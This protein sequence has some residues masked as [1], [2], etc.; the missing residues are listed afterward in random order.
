MLWLDGARHLAERWEQEG[1]LPSI[2]HFVL[3][4]LMGAPNS[5][6]GSHYANTQG[7]F[8]QLVQIEDVLRRENT[9]CVPSL[10]GPCVCVCD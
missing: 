8:Q 3:L 7:R 9:L 4:D 1:R 6:F 5:R 2:R 10:R